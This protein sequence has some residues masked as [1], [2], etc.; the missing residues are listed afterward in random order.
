[1]GMK[2]KVYFIGVDA[3][4]EESSI[5]NKLGALL[6]K[7]ALLS[8]VKEGDKAALKL[9]FGEGG[10]TGYVKPAYVREI[11]DAVLAQKAQPFLSDTNTLYCG[12]RTNSSDHLKL[13]YEHGFTLDAVHANVIIP[14]D[15]QK[16]NVREVELN[17]SHVKTAKI[18]RVYRDADCLIGIA[19]FKGHLMTGFGG[20]LKNIGMGCATRDGKLFQHGGMAPVVMKRKCTGCGA[21]VSVCPAN[22]VLVSE[23]KAR[24]DPAACIGCASC[25]AACKFSAIDV[26][27]EAGGALIQERMIE[28]AKAVLMNKQGKAIF[29]NFLMKI[30]KEC[31]CIAK[32]DPRVV[33]DIGILASTD[34]VAIDTAS[35]DLVSEKAGE[36]IIKRLHP[37]RS[38]RDQ[39]KYA[40][41][42][43]L[44]SMDY[45][46]EY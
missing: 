10:N 6:R 22:A 45:E 38:G 35:Y 34:P 20:A 36:D 17:A 37:S 1:M 19:H 16:Q 11:V 27:W 32:D 2:S 41:D 8:V 12:R 21:C 31:D 13:A 25:I 9:H 30:T 29:Y 4:E 44:G 7:S 28:Y 3:N 5:V 42:I 24:V 40:C 18:G 14:D 33:A 46:L 39:L 26:N 23:G 15:T 43:G